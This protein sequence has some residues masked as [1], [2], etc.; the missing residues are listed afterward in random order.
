MTIQK[1]DAAIQE[2]VVREMK[3]DTRLEPS[4]IGVTVTDGVVTL[5]GTVGSWGE[6]HAAQEA[7]HAV[8]GVLD[9]ANDIRVQRFGTHVRPDTEIAA[10]V[11]AALQWDVFVPEQRIRTTVTDGRVTL[12]GDVESWKQREAAEAA[13]RNLSGIHSIVNDIA[14]HPTN[15]VAPDVASAI[16][17][18]LVRHAAR[19][20][21][22]VTVEMD[23][24]RAV[25]RGEVQSW[26]ERELVLGAIKGTHG[27]RTV[28]SHLRVQPYATP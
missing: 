9:V 13:I 1:T 25:V 27:V 16:D 11:R 18:A 2:D 23:G 4:E 7:A 12:E 26:R 6:R 8:Q 17:D 15:Q 10:A 5:V 20:A 14:V 3:W 24:D 28:R 22:H 21:K 19:E